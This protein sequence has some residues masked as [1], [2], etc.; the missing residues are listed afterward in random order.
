VDPNFEEMR[1]MYPAA[2]GR[3]LNALDVAQ[4]RRVLVLGSA[5]AG[6]LLGKEN[7]IGKTV[8]LEGVP[9]TV[10]GILQ[11]K[12]QT[13]MNNG[14]DS[15]RAI[16]PNSTL[17]TMFGRLYVNSLV[18]RPGDP[19]RQAEVKREI[20]RCLPASITFIL[21]MNGRCSSGISLKTKR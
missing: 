16:I 21:T 9:F 19:S 18:V 1:R 10:I 7:P 17:R 13:S 14:P 11:E 2:G 3:F 5:I 12:I 4:Q 15:R 6:D 8:L 20:F